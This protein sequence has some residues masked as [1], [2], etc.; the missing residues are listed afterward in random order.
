MISFLTLTLTLIGGQ[1]RELD[2]LPK[3]PREKKLT[4]FNSPDDEEEEE[5]EDWQAEECEAEELQTSPTAVGG[6]L[7]SGEIE[8]LRCLLCGALWP[9]VACFRTDPL[10]KRRLEADGG[11]EV[12]FHPC[13][14]NFKR[15]GSME[16]PSWF[17]FVEKVETSRIFLRDS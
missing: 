13:S 2:F 12:S 9:N 1:L 5:E 11:E 8:L 7:S 4:S 6:K 15:E 16:D 14:V 17:A 10:G 3:G